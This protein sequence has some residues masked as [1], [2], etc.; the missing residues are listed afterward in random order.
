MGGAIEEHH[1]K[2][3]IRH[4]QQMSGT[5]VTPA[6]SDH[7][8]LSNPKGQLIWSWGGPMGHDLFFGPMALVLCHCIHP[9]VVNVSSWP[10]RDDAL[11]GA[12]YVGWP[13]GGGC[14]LPPGGKF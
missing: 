14:V 3:N 1:R 4:T 8:S 6:T 12:P 7:N 11:Q 9:C 2:L 10:G 13:V 5:L